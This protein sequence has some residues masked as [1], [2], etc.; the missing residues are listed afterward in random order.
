VGHRTGGKPGAKF[1][2]LAIKIFQRGENIVQ[3]A[4]TRVEKLRGWENLR[5]FAELERQNNT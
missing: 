2:S 3:S 1:G 4:S 5:N